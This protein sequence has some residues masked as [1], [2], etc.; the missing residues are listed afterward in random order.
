M[1]YPVG[2]SIRNIHRTTDLPG[3]GAG[4]LD[5]FFHELESGC[6]VVTCLRITHSTTGL[7][8][9]QYPILQ[10]PI[11]ASAATEK[12][13]LPLRQASGRLGSSHAHTQSQ[14]VD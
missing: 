4:C 2:Y 7:L 6:D 13:D 5:L 12:R 14:S 3:R 11:T 1:P 8:L 10:Y 9:R